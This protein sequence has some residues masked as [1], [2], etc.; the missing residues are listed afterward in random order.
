MAAR[1]DKI[2]ISEL[3]AT[4]PMAREISYSSWITYFSTND[5]VLDTIILAIFYKLVYTLI[6][7]VPEAW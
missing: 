3:A 6:F 7:K 2:V 1:I 4:D 5:N